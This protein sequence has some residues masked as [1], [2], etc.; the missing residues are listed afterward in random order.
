[1]N[2]SS[3]PDSLKIQGAGET[4][5]STCFITYYD[6]AYGE[7]PLQYLPLSWSFGLDFD[8]A[9]LQPKGIEKK[10]LSTTKPLVCRPA[11]PALKYCPLH[12]TTMHDAQCPEWLQ[13]C[14]AVSL[15]RKET[16]SA[17]AST[18]PGWAVSRAQIAR[19][20]ARHATKLAASA[21]PPRDR[22]EEGV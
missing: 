4:D 6:V 17:A 2:I 19:D 22:R 11:G 18:S 8:L 3:G 12:A 15:N 13:Q 1:V 21:G 14:R 5:T 20:H 7:G 16:L 10:I 9:T